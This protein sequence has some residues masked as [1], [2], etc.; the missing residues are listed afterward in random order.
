MFRIISLLSICLLLSA[1]VGKPVNTNVNTY[2]LESVAN[3]RAGAQDSAGTLLV[4]VSTLSPAYQTS[5][6]VYMKHPFQLNNFAK[7]EWVASPAQM[8]LPLLLESLRNAGHFHA[9]VATP[10]TAGSDYRLSVKVVKLQQNFLHS[11][12]Q[13]EMELLADL[14]DAKLNTVVASK[15]F[16]SSVTAAE[17]TP[18]AGVVAANIAVANLLEQIVEFAAQA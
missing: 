8:L 14:I 11:P 1:C 10:Y 12:S 18:L 15:R 2:A 13:V 3:K 7:N 5:Q 4:S 17:D 9:V 6:M 16:T